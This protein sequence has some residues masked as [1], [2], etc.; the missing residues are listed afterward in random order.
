MFPKLQS[1]YSYVFELPLTHLPLELHIC[2]SIGSDNGLSP[3][4]RQAIIRTNIGL[5]SIGPLETNFSE[6]LIEIHTFSFTK[7]R[8]NMLFAKWRP[9]CPGGDELMSIMESY[10]TLTW[11]IRQMVFPLKIMSYWLTGHSEGYSIGGSWEKVNSH[12]E[13]IFS[14]KYLPD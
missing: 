1:L 4:Q 6:I 11:P 2:I 10:L 5:L 9:Y 13:V 7:M 3:G 8:W 14:S 12:H